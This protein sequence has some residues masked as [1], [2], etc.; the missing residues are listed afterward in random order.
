MKSRVFELQSMLP[1][2]II[3]AAVGLLVAGL[4]ENQ[5]GPNGQIDSSHP[6]VQQKVSKH[7]ELTAQQLE[8]QRRR[9]ALQNSQMIMDYSRSEPEV[10]YVPQKEG[11]D[12]M[13][14]Q[15][16]AIVAQDINRRQADPTQIPNTP[17]EL[18]HHQ[19]FQ[20]QV[21]AEQTEAYKKEYAR[22]FIENAR[23]AGWDVR[24]NEDYK[25]IQVRPL[26]R[27]QPAMKLFDQ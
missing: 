4:Q 18:I 10:A 1:L 24:L 22:Q 26:N 6:D 16:A 12:L 21:N 20:E 3:A 11:A 8:M 17:S 14:D 7:L 9:M 23:R 15:T 19:L 5:R 2:L 13:H 27:N 25:V